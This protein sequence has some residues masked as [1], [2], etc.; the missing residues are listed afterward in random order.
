MC[1]QLLFKSGHKKLKSPYKK[2][3]NAYKNWKVLTKTILFVATAHH[4]IWQVLTIWKFL[5]SIKHSTSQINSFLLGSII[6]I[7]ILEI[8]VNKHL[9]G[10]LLNAW[11]TN[12]VLT[13]YQHHRSTP[14]LESNSCQGEF[15]YFPLPCEK[16]SKARGVFR[17]WSEI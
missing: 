9:W 4:S 15:R 6:L 12:F 13:V 1:R 16:C 17:T 7:A 5:L 8:A 2:L 11:R 3:K 14:P 10:L